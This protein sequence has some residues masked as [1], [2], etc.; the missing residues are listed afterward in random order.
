M[1]MVCDTVIKRKGGD[2][3]SGEVEIMIDKRIGFRGRV[4]RI[5]FPGDG[6]V[7][8]MRGPSEQNNWDPQQ[9]WT[10]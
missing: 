3:S 7:N 6:N 1:M 10:N 2:A 5:H 9:F 8:L 4:C